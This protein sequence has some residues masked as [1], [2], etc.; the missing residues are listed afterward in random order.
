M[1]GVVTLRGGLIVQNAA[2][3]LALGLENRG[4]VLTAKDGQL[5]VSNGAQL[6]AEDRA[7]ITAHRNHLLAIAGY[8]APAVE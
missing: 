1:S 8:E 5:L 3:S 6:T 7:Q 4:H 2:I